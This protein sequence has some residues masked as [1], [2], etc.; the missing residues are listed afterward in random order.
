[1]S[2]ARYRFLKVICGICILNFAVFCV[3]AFE[4]GGD[5]VNGKVIDG[6]FYLAENGRLT[7]VSEGVFTYS[8]WHV[9]SLAVTFPLA[10]LAGYLVKMESRERRRRSGLPPYYETK[11][12]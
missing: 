5:A 6:N 9:R 7:E 11:T 1:M 12:P 2:D 3:V 4:I 8:L 10:M